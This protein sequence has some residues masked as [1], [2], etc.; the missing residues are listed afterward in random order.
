MEFPTK[1][2]DYHHYGH[3]EP[4]AAAAADFN[5]RYYGVEKYEDHDPHHVAGPHH[6]EPFYYSGRR[7]DPAQHYHH[8]R[9]YSNE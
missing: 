1:G 2:M 3:Y 7:P 9:Y 4:R 5:Q 8:G 6:G